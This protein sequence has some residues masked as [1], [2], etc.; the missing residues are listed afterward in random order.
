[1]EN[2]SSLK[3]PELRL[4]PD[5]R[6]DISQESVILYIIRYWVD[7]TL[8]QKPYIDDEISSTQ[9]QRNYID[10][11]CEKKGTI[12]HLLEKTKDFHQ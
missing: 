8:N 11:H 1:L 7:P 2:A 10:V 3:M 4:Y 5:F 6:S 12:H 9:I